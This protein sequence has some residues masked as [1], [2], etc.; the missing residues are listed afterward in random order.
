MALGAFSQPGP[1]RPAVVARLA[2]TLGAAKPTNSM[3]HVVITG[4]PGA[5]KTTL[6]SELAAMGYKNIEESA[7]TVIAERVSEGNSPRPAPHEFAQEILRRDVEK[8]AQVPVSAELVFF[9]RGVVEAVGGL[10]AAVPIAGSEVQSLLAKY[11]V[12]HTVFILPPWREIYVTD[13]E[14]DHSFEHAVKVHSRLAD[15]YHACG[16]QLHEVP[17]LAALERA[18]FVLQA[19]TSGA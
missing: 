5:G 19:I 8:Y 17:R 2:R 14:R 18:R 10:Q 15:W 12:H 4:G 11:Q 7:R 1:W 6:L 13:A 16:Y 9:D 3:P